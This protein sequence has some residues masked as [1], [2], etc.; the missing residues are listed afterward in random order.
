MARARRPAL[1]D[2]SGAD[3]MITIVGTATPSEFERKKRSVN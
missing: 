3:I 2:L 1:L